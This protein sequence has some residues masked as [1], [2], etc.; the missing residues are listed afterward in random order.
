MRPLTGF[1]VAA[2]APLSG[3]QP[4]VS[5]EEIQKRLRNPF[6]ETA[7]LSYTNEFAFGSQNGRAYIGT[8][9][10]VMPF[11]RGPLT[12]ISRPAFTL[13]RVPTGVGGERVMVTGDLS[14]QLFLTPAARS[15]SIIWGI[16][17]AFTFPTASRDL[18]GNGKWSGGPTIA[19]AV[20]P[21][22]LSLA[23]GVTNQWSFAGD[24]NRAPVNQ[25]AV[26]Y[27]IDY[28]LRGGWS[29]SSGPTMTNDWRG[30]AGEH[31]FV[32]VGG[33]V[34]KTFNGRVPLQF[35]VAAY[36]NVVRPDFASSWSL[37][38]SVTPVL[39]IK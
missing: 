3:Q 24:S 15:R 31:W 26:E 13:A 5:T 22:K 4:G 16:G 21:G 11:T 37:Q 25:L 32:P 14:Y 12:F 18:A 36:R 34:T 29:L 19:I 27:S 10:P 8:F 38:F 33:G 6:S 1:L 28:R 23:A 20:Q 9:Q 7:S 39:A 35:G 17:P 2:L 30:A